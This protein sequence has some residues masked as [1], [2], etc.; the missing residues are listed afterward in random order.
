M[1]NVKGL[2]VEVVFIFFVINIYSCVKYY[3]SCGCWG[4]GGG[5]GR[6]IIRKD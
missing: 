3:C 1:R 6:K 5:G 4:G 2:S